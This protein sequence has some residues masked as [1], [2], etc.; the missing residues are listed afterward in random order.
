MFA[1]K[2]IKKSKRVKKFAWKQGKIDD[3]LETI[4]KNNIFLKYSKLKKIRYT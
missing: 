2:V 4:V 1:K 3:V